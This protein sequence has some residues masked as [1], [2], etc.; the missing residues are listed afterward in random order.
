MRKISLFIVIAA[1][2]LLSSCGV[3][4]FAPK[5]R[6]TPGPAIRPGEYQPQGLVEEHQYRCSVPGPTY[7][8]MIVYMPAD[9]HTS[10]KAYPVL[11]LLHGARGYET[12]WIRFGDVYHTADSLWQN[13]LARE[14]IIVMPNVNQ[15]NSDRDYEGGRFKDAYESILEVD[16]VVESAFVHDVVNVVDSLYRTLPGKENRA[17]AGLSVGAYQSIFFGANHPD[18]FGYIGAFSPYMWCMSL[19][20]SYRRIFYHGLHKKLEKEFEDPPLGYYLY[21]GKK[22]IMRPSTRNY[23]RYMERKRY[24]HQYLVYPGSHDWINGGWADE[25]KDLMQKIFR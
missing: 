2:L 20:N 21:A 16:G 8:R 13:S 23:H 6:W 11:Y 15:Y 1:V 14:C 24:P 10:G 4:R 5:E 25:L 12:A 7:R 9:Y 17:I 3:L 22:D 18:I 19:P